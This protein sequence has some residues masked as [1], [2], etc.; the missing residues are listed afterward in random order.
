MNRVRL[1]QMQVFDRLSCM[2]NEQKEDD[3]LENA[4]EPDLFR[5]PVL[6]AFLILVPV[7]LVLIATIFNDPD[8]AQVTDQAV[9]KTS[10]EPAFS[11]GDAQAVPSNEGRA[12]RVEEGNIK[13]RNGRGR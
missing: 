6:W 11:D 4:L 9:V 7:M 5:G 10:Q 3:E 13:E 8:Q 2:S 12:V 1:L